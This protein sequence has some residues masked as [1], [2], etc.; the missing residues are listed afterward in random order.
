M[1]HLGCL[2]LTGWLSLTALTALGCA[3]APAAAPGAASPPAGVPSDAPVELSG[4]WND[5]D[6]DLV[7]REI[8][9][10]FL[11][12]TW[13]EAWRREHAGATPTLRLYPIKNRTT[14][15]VDHRFFTKRFEAALVQSGQIRVLLALDEQPR[16]SDGEDIT[17][18]SAPTGEAEREADFILNGTLL[19][20]EDV[21]GQRKVSAYLTTVEIVETATQR[22]AWIGQKRLR[23]LIETGAR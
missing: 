14:G 4:E 3:G 20:Q 10:D 8:I 22:K 16:S 2:W 7:A 17:T 18:T 12:S 19:L 21:A 23:K 15:Y 5:V 13:I 11:G 1:R 6:A 9:T